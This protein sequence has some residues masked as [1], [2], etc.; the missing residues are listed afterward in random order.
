MAPHAVIFGLEGE[1]L[2][3][4]EYAF[5]K[6][7]NPW[8]FILFARNV[9]TPE[10]VSRLCQDIRNCVGRDA[11]I[12]IDQEGGR[13]R[14]LRPPHWRDYPA[15]SVYGEIYQ[16]DREAGRRAIWLGH[17]LMAD[18]LR[19]IGVTADCAPVLDLPQ[20][21][22]DP[23]ISDRAFGSEVAQIVDLA[24]A[25][26]SGLMSGGVAPVIKHIPGHGRAKVD[27]HLELPEID[28]PLAQLSNTDTATFKALASAPMAMTA[29]AVYSAV[30]TAPL[31]VSPKA[32]QSLVREH[33]GFDGLLMTDDLD[34][35]ALK[36]G[37]LR[38]K[39]EQALAAGCDIALHCNGVMRDM[40][41]VADGA[42]PLSGKALERAAIADLCA[43]AP[44][45]L[46]RATTDAE[47][48][49]LLALV[50]TDVA[51]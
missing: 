44:E 8:G 10:Q 36:A 7:V 30:D 18:D 28:T 47:F 25:A 23:I 39:A 33:I 20:Q 1:T 15:G 45:P 32:I 2:T 9:D 51:A 40:T 34:M 41:D 29:H 22:A 37:S 31:T 12:F 38:Q 48:D 6:D 43:D 14:R 5:F 4:D 49:E 35:K 17:R 24:N 11:L 13:V 26:M 21:E 3:A 50:A 19:T 16:T 27:S 42:K 46:D